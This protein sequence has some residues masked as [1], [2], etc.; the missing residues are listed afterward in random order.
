MADLEGLQ[1]RCDAL[2]LETQRIARQ[3]KKLLVVTHIDADGLA[4]GTTVFAALMRKGANV[5]LRTVPDLDMRAIRELEEQRFDFYVFTD[6]GSALIGELEKAFGDRFM[7][8]DHHLLADADMQRVGLANAWQFGF[9]G[10]KEA[11]S[12]TMAYFFARSLD[13]DNRDLSYLAVV[14]AVADRQ[15]GGPNRSLTGLNRLALEDAQGAG[16]ISVSKD[17]IFSGRETRPIHE[18]IALTSSPYLPGLSG[19]KDAVL[20]SLVQ[21]GITLREN[22]RWRTITELTSEEKM[23]L[24]EVI[25]GMILS[26]GTATSAIAGLVGEVY[27]LELEDSFTPLRDARDFA[28][29]LNA[30]GRMDEAGVGAAICLGDRKGAVVAATKIL[31][32]YRTSIGKALDGLTTQKGRLDEHG[33]VLL[34]HGEGVVDE[35]LLGPVASIL[36]SSPRFKDKVVLARTNSGETQFKISCRVGDSVERANEVNLGLIMREA[37]EAVEGVGGGHSMAAG[38]KI[39]ATGDEAFTKMVLERLHVA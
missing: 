39:P 3:G 38:A 11:C 5:T 13:E 18:A 25:A 24:T 31:T 9:D 26:D 33:R 22:G 19:S 20:A 1:K 2:A 27:D 10:G 30:C 23:K 29:L 8:L 32:D 6:L 21:S 15:D 17:L 36:A 4:S 12:S 7:V 34:I 14:G 37:A 28:T 16:L 35:R